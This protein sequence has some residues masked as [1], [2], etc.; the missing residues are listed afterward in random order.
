MGL[1][2]YRKG[3]G[4]NRPISYGQSDRVSLPRSPHRQAI[5]ASHF[6][7]VLFAIGLAAVCVHFWASGQSKGR[8]RM[9]RAE[10]LT[11]TQSD[12]E[13]GGKVELPVELLQLSSGFNL[14][15]ASGSP[16]TDLKKVVAELSSHSSRPIVIV[17][18]FEPEAIGFD[19]ASVA[20]FINIKSP[21]FLPNW[22][23][24]RLDHVFEVSGD[25]RVLGERTLGQSS[26]AGVR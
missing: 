18:Y 10:I 3:G 11:E 2:A 15:A 8:Y 13:F 26:R 22:I 20:R 19:K 1:W 21:A 24:G 17:A 4:K 16:C 9:D 5:C 6:G 7:N 23:R 14:I 25:H 12:P